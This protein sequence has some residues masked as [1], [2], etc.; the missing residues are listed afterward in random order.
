M[1]NIYTIPL[2]EAFSVSDGCPFCRI[3]EKLEKETLEYTLGAAMMEPSVRIEMNR[4]GFCREHFTKL[5][6]SKNKLSLAL[7]LESRLDSAIAESGGADISDEHS[8]FVCNRVN[9][10]LE[11]YIANAAYMHQSVEAFRSLFAGQEFF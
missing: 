3:R 8:C 2:N 11:R 1:E 10:T 9:G 6:A 7:I 4:L 5:A